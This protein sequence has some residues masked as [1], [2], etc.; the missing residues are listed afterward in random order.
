MRRLFF[1]SL[2]TFLTLFALRP[3]T[4]EQLMPGDN[5]DRAPKY[6][7]FR[8]MLFDAVARKDASFIRAR[9]EGAR[10][11]FGMP[12][13]LDAQFKLDDP[14]DPFW[15]I[16]ARMLTLGGTYHDGTQADPTGYVEYPYV[17]A[18]FPEKTD[19]Y[20]HVAVVGREVNVR[21]K[22]DPASKV[23]A[24]VSYEILQLLDHGEEWRQVKVSDKVTGYVNHEYLYGPLDYRMRLRNVNGRWMI[25]LFLAGD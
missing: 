25:E 21:E 2:L 19:P 6:A 12:T 7:V 20:P 13:T 1:A 3:V 17:T 23:V 4:A 16:I 18:R 5:T 10:V 22:P 8:G 11:T 24:T 9:S 14:E 15:R